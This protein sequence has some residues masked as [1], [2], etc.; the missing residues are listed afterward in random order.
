M[1]E[2]VEDANLVELVAEHFGGRLSG[3]MY[4]FGCV[5]R[6]FASVAETRT[7]R[8]STGPFARKAG[9]RP[10]ETTVDWT[11]K[12]ESSVRY[13][14]MGNLDAG[15]GDIISMIQN[16]S[17]PEIYTDLELLICGSAE[18]YQIRSVSDDGTCIGRP[19][20]LNDSIVWLDMNVS[21]QLEDPI[22]FYQD[23]PRQ[24]KCPI[25]VT[26]YK[27]QHP[28]VI[29]RVDRMP[30]KYTRLMSTERLIYVF[31]EI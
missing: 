27:E 29:R 31:G 24:L 8:L 25:S 15:V 23:L 30:E 18:Y 13:C 21:K 6:V 20:W 10:R 7:K 16:P 3:E 11:W 14:I 12:Q 9:D 5:S 2:V 22:D 19:L 28:E 17:N 26:L 4:P 1:D